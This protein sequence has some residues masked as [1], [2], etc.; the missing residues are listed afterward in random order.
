LKAFTSPNPDVK[1]TIID[2]EEKVV[3]RVTYAVS[4]LHDRI[5]LFNIEV[6]EGYKRKG[7]GLAIV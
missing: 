6:E 4:P 1:A 7:F 2:A 3:G 5:Y